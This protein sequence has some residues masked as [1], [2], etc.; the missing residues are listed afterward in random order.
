MLLRVCMP[1][2]CAQRR[3]GTGGR[4]GGVEREMRGVELIPV[5]VFRVYESINSLRP[6]CRDARRMHVFMFQQEGRGPVIRRGGEAKKTCLSYLEKGTTTTTT[7][8]V[9]WCD[10]ELQQRP[11][12][13]TLWCG[14]VGVG[15]IVSLVKTSTTGRSFFL[16]CPPPRA[17]E[18]R[19]T[20]HHHGDAHIHNHQATHTTTGLSS[21]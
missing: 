19:T 20:R 3:G 11:W 21:K 2:A 18:K 1:S 14:V 6:P 15:R 12:P 8:L 4:E 17:R 10:S 7:R 9:S 16:P 5:L 13:W